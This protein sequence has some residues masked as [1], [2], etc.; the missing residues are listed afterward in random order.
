[1][2]RLLAAVMSIGLA[3]GAV[4]QDASTKTRTTGEPTAPKATSPKPKELT[5]PM[6]IL[7]KADQALKAAQSVS[8]Q[9]LFRGTNWMVERAP[10]VSGSVIVSGKGVGRPPQYR[11]NVDVRLVS[12]EKYKNLTFGS[13][14]TS[15]YF[16]DPQTKTAYVGTDPEWGGSRGTAAMAVVLP[17][18]THPN[19]LYDELN[20]DLATLIGSTTVD[21]VDCYEIQLQN[22]DVMGETIWMISKK[23]FLP[24]TRRIVMINGK[25]QEATLEWVFTELKIDPKFDKDPFK[26]HPPEGYKKTDQP[27]P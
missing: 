19:A 7:Q 18:F 25:F 17:H 3:S 1:M 8:Y 12:E 9:G 23:D 24:R 27:A 14:G 5:D 16:I 20:M 22:A 11:V 15:H 10:K 6:E 21:G 4:A 26:L 2:R 13:D